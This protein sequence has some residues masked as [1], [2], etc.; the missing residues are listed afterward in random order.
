[1]EIKKYI[2]LI[3]FIQINVQVYA[4]V[5]NKYGKQGL[6]NVENT[7]DLNKPISTAAQSALNTKADVTLSNLSNI[8][9]ARANLGVSIGSNV[10]AYDADLDDLADGTLSASKVENAITTAG[11]SGEVWT[12]DGSG[13]GTWALPPNSIIEVGSGLAISG[14][15]T[16][17]GP[18]N[19][20]L[21]SGGTVGQVLTIGGDGVPA[22]E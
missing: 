5:V 15:G 13:A 9:T 11:T 8:V 2:I 7:S 6:E 18:Y 10:Q 1:M 16:V 3:F 17:V 21:P 4:Q 12:S 19:I 22:W 14:S 20:S